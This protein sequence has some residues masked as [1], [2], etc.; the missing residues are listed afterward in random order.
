MN[1]YTFSSQNGLRSSLRTDNEQIIGTRAYEYKQLVENIKPIHGL[2]EKL[3]A[4]NR[5]K[6][7]YK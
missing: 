7:E 1:R 2:R 5:R 6:N 3:Q 4:F